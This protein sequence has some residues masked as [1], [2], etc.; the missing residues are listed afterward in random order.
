M[1]FGN[2]YNSSTGVAAIFVMMV[3]PSTGAKTFYEYSTGY[4]PSKDPTSN[5]SNNGIYYTTATDLDGDNITDYIYAGDLF[6]NVWRFDV[7]NTDPTKWAVSSYA[8]TKQPLFSTPTNG[9][10]TS[11]SLQ[12][13]TTKLIVGS[14]SASATQPRL[15]VYFGTGQ[16]IPMTTTSG[17]T[18][19]T[20]NQGFMVS[21]TGIWPAGTAYRRP[22]TPAAPRPAARSPPAAWWPRP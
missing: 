3:D 11:K 12:P 18:Y 5:S 1:I 9:S 8:G 7:T 4:G 15:M 13:I 17:N 19:A 2:G 21:G 10:G 16:K 14:I 22:S 6:G 20:G